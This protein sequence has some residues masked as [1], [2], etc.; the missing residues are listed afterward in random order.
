MYYLVIAIEDYDIELKEA[1]SEQF[2]S[3]VIQTRKQVKYQ[4][5]RLKS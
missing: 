1:L 2:G 5:K 4:W 3:N